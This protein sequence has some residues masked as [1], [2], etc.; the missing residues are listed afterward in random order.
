M[1]EHIKDQFLQNINRLHLF[2]QKDKVLLAVSGGAD[3]MLLAHLFLQTNK[4]FGI[5][6]CNFQLRAQEA[7]E[8]EK[9]VRQFAEDN[10]IPFHII[11]FDTKQ[12]A[13]KEK[14]S[15]EEA[16]RNLRYHWF[17]SLRQQH[18][19]QYIATAHH[20]NDNAETLLFNL[21]RGTGIAG[22][23]GILPKRRFLIRPLL[24]FTKEEIYSYMKENNLSYKEDQTNKNS[25]YTRNYIRN[26]I[27]P[28]IEKRFPQLIATMGDNIQ[29]FSEA[30]AFYQK[31]LNEEV[32]H[33]IHQK[34]N[35]IIIPIRKL[36]NSSS[37]STLAFEIFKAYGF[38]YKQ[39]QQILQ[40]AESPSG[41]VVYSHSHQLLKDRKLFIISPLNNKSN[42]HF[43]IDKD[44][45]EVEAQNLVLKI[46]SKSSSSYRLKEDQNIAALDKE[47]LAFPLVLRKWRQGDYFYPL[48][49]RKKKKI[50]RFFIDQKLSLH[51][52]EKIW[53]LTSGQRIL[54]IVGMRIDDRFKIT[55]QTKEVMEIK[56]IT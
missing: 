24:I 21:F 22:L 49:M 15:I 27:I 50:S 11:R 37:I 38:R 2:Q 47:K 53:I 29:R 34:E 54:W 12:H 46:T 33:L 25:D 42:S 5:A 9:F 30:E 51:Q 31:A 3:S 43:V 56:K 48:G 35:E 26:E 45:K 7:D 16:A 19:Y 17:E 40:L 55:S 44:Q 14:L 28:K 18:G 41:K 23:H 32:H 20:K 8:D 52:K 10:K 36:L 4:S 13:R 39:S 6:H 1:S